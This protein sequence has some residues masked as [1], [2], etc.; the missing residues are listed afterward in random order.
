MQISVTLF[1]DDT[2]IYRTISSEEDAAKLQHDLNM[3]A[4]WSDTC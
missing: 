4:A 1:P 3:L 2:K